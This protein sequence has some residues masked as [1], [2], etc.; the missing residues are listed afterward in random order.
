M[1]LSAPRDDSIEIISLKPVKKLIWINP[2]I[3]SAPWDEYLDIIALN[4]V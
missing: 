4:Q 2:M 3:L 1:F